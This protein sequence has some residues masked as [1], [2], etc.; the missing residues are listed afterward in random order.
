MRIL[1]SKKRFIFS[2]IRIE[3][4][5]AKENKKKSS[6]ASKK[7]KDNKSIKK[8]KREDSDSSVL[9]KNLLW[10][11]SQSKNTI[12]LYGKCS[13]STDN[14]K[15]ICAMVNKHKWK[16]QKNFKSYRKSNN[17]VNALIQKKF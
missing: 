5:E 16:K 3:N 12:F 4:L 7:S 14:C 11:T 17:E 9:V 13:R 1:L 6:V 10:S 8:R 15:D 2:K